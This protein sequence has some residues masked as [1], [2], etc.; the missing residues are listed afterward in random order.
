MF[1][2]CCSKYRGKFIFCKF[3]IGIQLQA[4]ENEAIFYTI[5]FSYDKHFL[6]H[7]LSTDY[8]DVQPELVWF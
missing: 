1:F 3:C 2:F 5:G 7:L 8:H 4:F 6:G